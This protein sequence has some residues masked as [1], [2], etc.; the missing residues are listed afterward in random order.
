MDSGKLT[1]NI[2]R[3]LNDYDLGHIDNDYTNEL[4]YIVSLDTSGIVHLIENAKYFSN[5]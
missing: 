5:T 3:D 2:K 1:L 4:E